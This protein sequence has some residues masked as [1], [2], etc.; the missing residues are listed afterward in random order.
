MAQHDALISDVLTTIGDGD[1]SACIR[2][3]KST[4]QTLCSFIAVPPIIHE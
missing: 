1:L 2:T 3:N 4:Q